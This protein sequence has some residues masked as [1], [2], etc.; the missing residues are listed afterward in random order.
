MGF[1]LHTHSFYSDGLLTPSQL[2]SEAKAIGLEGIALTDHDTVDGLPEFLRMSEGQ[3]I[4]AIPGVELSTEYQGTESHI[5]G[6]GINY[7]DPK[8]LSCLSRVLASRKVRAEKILQLLARQGIKLTWQEIV[9]DAPGGFVGRYQIYRAMKEKGYINED[10]DKKAF[11]YYLGLQGVAYVPH[12]ELSSI[13]ALKLIKEVGGVSVL[14]H[15]GRLIKDEWIKFLAANGL[16]GIEV[17]YPEHTP[18]MI[19]E[20]LHLA[21]ELGLFVTGGSDYHG[22]SEERR[23]GEAVVERKYIEKL[24]W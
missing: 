8:L 7:Q 23:L 21:E 13:E 12:H 24:F 15:P 22:V 5:L 20:Y 4:I 3:G 14:A 9:K 10:R 2:L 17:F 11:D 18:E 6:Y 1:D 16:E 19:Q